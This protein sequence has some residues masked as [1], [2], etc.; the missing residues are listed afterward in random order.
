MIQQA[1]AYKAQRVIRA[2]G[3]AQRFQ[4]VLKEYNNAKAVTR[5]RLYLESIERIMPGAQKFILDQDRNSNV[6]P[7]L[8]L[9]EIV[10]AP[11]V[12]ARGLTQTR[13]AQKN[14]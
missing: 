10:R 13:D 1:E 8:P 7:R 11:S 14:Q 6:L 5:D 4:A 9:K 3:D 12:Q 2:Q